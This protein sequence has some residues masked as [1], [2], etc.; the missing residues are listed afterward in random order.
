MNID[1]LFVPLE[2]NMQDGIAPEPGV[3]VRPAILHRLTEVRKTMQISRRAF[4][5]KL[6]IGLEELRAQEALADVPV[7]VLKAWARVLGVSV[8]ALVVEQ[9]E[10]LRV[11]H[12][13]RSHAN[14]LMNVA[15]K[16]RDRSRRRGIQRLAQ[17]FVDQLKEIVPALRQTPSKPPRPDRADGKTRIPAIKPLPESV[18]TLHRDNGTYGP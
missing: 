17:T 10:C 9:D 18:F 3:E 15:T 13:A 16:L 11:P 1:Q 12:F 14:R 8:A 6:G 4:A 7:S 2:N 5:A